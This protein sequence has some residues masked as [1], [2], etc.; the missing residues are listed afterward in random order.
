LAQGKCL[1]NFQVEVRA[2]E[3]DEPS[4]GN[5]VFVARGSVPAA[6]LVALY[7]G[8]WFPS[9]PIAKIQWGTEAQSYSWSHVLDIHGP[10]AVDAELTHCTRE[11]VVAYHLC[12]D[13]GIMDGFR[14]DSRVRTDCAR[15][16]YAVGQLVN[17][18]PRGQKPNVKLLQLEPLSMPLAVNRVH[19]GLWY[20]DPNTWSEVRVSPNIQP[21]TIALQATRHLALGEELLL[22]YRLRRPHPSWYHPAE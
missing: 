13:G 15:S 18:P 12:C 20:L 7:A 2:S 4:S 21:P 17:H 19:D 16:P 1:H 6:S 10:D 8:I 9:V 11:E 14:A 22:N 3:I 5:G